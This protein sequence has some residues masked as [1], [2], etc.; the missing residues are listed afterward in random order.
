VRS[1]GQPLA[2]DPEVID[3]AIPLLPETLESRTR[4]N[5]DEPPLSLGEEAL[6]AWR[7]ERPKVKD[8]GE[9]DRSASLVKIGRALFDA[10][11]NRPV[12]V[13]ALRERD[14]ALGWCKYTGRSDSE[15]RYHEIVDKL[16]ES[17]RAQHLRVRHLKPSGGD[18]PPSTNGREPSD[19]SDKFNLTDM[20][21]A[22]RFAR[23]HGRKV[24]YCHDYG[25]FLIFDG[26]RWQRDRKR[27]AEA[28]AKETTRG[29]YGEAQKAQ[30]E[31]ERKKLA[32]WAMHSESRTRLEAMLFCARSEPGIPIAPDDLDSDNRLLNAQ[33]GTITLDTGDLDAHNPLDHITKL[34]PIEYDPNAEAPTWEGFLE[35][36]LPSESLRRFVQQAVGHSLLGEATEEVLFFLYGTGANGKSTFINTILETLGDYARQAPPEL[37]TIKGLSHPTELA[38]LKGAR[39]VASVE[40]EEGKR[41]AESLVKQ[42]TGRDRISARFMRQDFFDFKPTHTI[43]LA[44]NHKP[45]VRGTDL[46]IWRRIKMIPFT[47]TI[48]E[49][50]RDPKLQ[51]KL[52]AELPGVLAWAVRGCLDYLKRGLIEPDEVRAAT[53]A[54]RTE[55]DVLA[56][57]IEE[58]CVISARVEAKAT[59]LYNIYKGWCDVS[60]E[61]PET[62]RA[63][64]SRLTERGFER[65]KRG[66]VYYW[67]GIGI[68]ADSPGSGPS[69][70]KGPSEEN[71]TF[72][73]KTS[74]DNA[75]SGPSGL[76]SSM[77]A[78]VY[79]REGAKPKK[80]PDGPDGPA[81]EICE[82][83]EDPPEW[84]STQLERCREEEARYLKATCSSISYEVYGTASRWWEVKPVVE[85][86]LEESAS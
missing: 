35:R 66:G 28:L 53:E 27:Q 65:K 79:A 14:E 62:Q 48:P 2:W 4:S 84:L 78:F 44:A 61:K 82:Y 37:L 36:V 31:D 85:R 8:T 6:Q 86:W 52:R 42:L 24:R 45:V 23:D 74:T 60:G 33:N 83:L 17:G 9:I 55:M 59:P 25:G 72:A 16:E 81:K 69:E 76:K 29:I 54:Y 30:D 19:S 3:Q 73:G 13:A 10:G 64:G 43:F 32:K 15:E 75:P 49:D 40:V 20:G 80:G 12:I 71:P 26:K 51:Q 41:L 22:G 7:G 50:E 58:C 67:Q 56:A 11:A 1:V 34:A 63:F 39:F 5:A 46:A 57:F 18:P 21:N 70:E 38:N 77:N 47:V 68:L